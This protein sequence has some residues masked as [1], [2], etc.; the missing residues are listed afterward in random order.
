MH[1]SEKA[2]HTR[3]RWTTSILRETEETKIIHPREYP[4]ASS[5][6]VEEPTAKQSRRSSELAEDGDSF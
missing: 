2:G 4:M 3:S 1:V 5:I 6:N